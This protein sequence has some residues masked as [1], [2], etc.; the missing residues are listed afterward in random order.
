M[1]DYSKLASLI[2]A[3]PDTLIFRRFGALSA[4]NLQYLQAELVHLEHELRECTL[5]N[6]RSEDAAGKGILSKDWFTLAHSNE[7]TE[8]QWRIILRIRAKL[9][10]YGPRQK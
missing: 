9:K 7:G 3:Y 6:E 1:E 5:P 10:E 4:Q 8:L 2:G